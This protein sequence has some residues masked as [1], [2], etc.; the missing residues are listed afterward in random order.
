MSYCP[1]TGGN[2]RDF[3]RKRGSSVQRHQPPHRSSKPHA[4]VIPLHCFRKRKFR[5]Q[6]RKE[7]L[8][9]HVGGPALFLL[10]RKEILPLR[11]PANLQFLD[12][13]SLP[14]GKSRRRSGRLAGLIECH[15]F[16]RP[17]RFL[18]HRGL[19]GREALNHQGQSPWSSESSGG[20]K[21]ET[22]VFQHLLSRIF[23]DSQGGS[24]KLIG[25]FFNT[26]LEQQLGGGHWG[27]ALPL[28]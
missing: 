1:V 27:R 11:R 14:R 13:D 17:H 7:F 15:R 9:D 20:L 12:G 6:L 18:D 28:L 25:K 8:Q 5:D 3:D 2:P 23:E 24:N 16:G 10:H 4:C 22:L 19:A 21:R 26:D